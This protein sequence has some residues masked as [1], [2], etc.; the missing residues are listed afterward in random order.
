MLMQD[1]LLLQH[2]F[3]GWAVGLITRQTQCLTLSHILKKF[4]GKVVT[5]ER[6]KLLVLIA[7]KTT[8]FDAVVFGVQASLNTTRTVVPAFVVLETML[9]V[10]TLK[11]PSLLGFGEMWER[12]GN[13]INNGFF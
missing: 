13:G 2:S 10:G 11:L 1:T 7:E 9:T 8:E 4:L 5:K 12:E 3:Q 6:R